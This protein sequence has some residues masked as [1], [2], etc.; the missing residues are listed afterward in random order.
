MNTENI[1]LTFLEISL[2]RGPL[3]GKGPGDEASSLLVG[4]GEVY[5]DTEMVVG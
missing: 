3:G 1:C 4:L 2:V 5:E